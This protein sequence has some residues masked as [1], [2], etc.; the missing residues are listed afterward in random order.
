LSP[1]KQL[2]ILKPSK[3]NNAKLSEVHKGKNK[4]TLDIE[5]AFEAVSVSSHL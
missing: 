4:N 1:T 5:N 3:Q 2:F